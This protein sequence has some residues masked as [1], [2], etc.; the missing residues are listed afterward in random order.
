MDRGRCGQL[1]GTVDARGGASGEGPGLGRRAQGKTI[2]V[3]DIELALP[4][5]CLLIRPLAA[6]APTYKRARILQNI[7]SQHVEDNPL[8]RSSGLDRGG[9]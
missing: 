5:S 7:V 9:S 6:A 8:C 4:E 3:L 2:P 1:T